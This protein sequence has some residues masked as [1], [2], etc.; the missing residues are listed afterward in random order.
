MT[1]ISIPTDD[2]F[3]WDV[4]DVDEIELAVSVE[5]DCLYVDAVELLDRTVSD[6]G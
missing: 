3:G 5:S 1:W 2:D 6:A 4:G